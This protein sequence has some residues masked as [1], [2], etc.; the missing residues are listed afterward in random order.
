MS[1]ITHGVSIMVFGKLMNIQYNNVS[2][3]MLKTFLFYL[4]F[5]RI[6]KKHF[7]L[8]I[9]SECQAICIIVEAPCVVGPHL[10]QNCSQRPSAVFKSCPIVAEVLHT[11]QLLSMIMTTPQQ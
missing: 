11:I 3:C 7:F 5:F 4:L 2:P 8:N 1:K 6:F 10:C 9:Y